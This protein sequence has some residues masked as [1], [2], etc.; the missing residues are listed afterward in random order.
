MAE[1]IDDMRKLLSKEDDEFRRLAQ[2]HHQY[3]SRLA[4]LAV[5]ITLTPDEELEEKEL[6]KRKLW[7]KDQMAAKIRTYEAMHSV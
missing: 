7:L 2:Q 4:E 1:R 3:E 5:K 6:K